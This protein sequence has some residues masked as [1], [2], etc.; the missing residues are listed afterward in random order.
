MYLRET[1]KSPNFSDSNYRRGY[2][3]EFLAALQFLF[4][5]IPQLT[6]QRMSRDADVSQ[7]AF[8]FTVALGFSDKTKRGGCGAG[9]DGLEERN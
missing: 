5:F 6:L 7:D 8:Y 3:Q 9:L 2:A 4:I 1:L